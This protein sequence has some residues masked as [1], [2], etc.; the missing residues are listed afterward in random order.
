MTEISKP[1]EES[2]IY[3]RVVVCVSHFMH[4]RREKSDIPCVKV[5]GTNTWQPGP[6]LIKERLSRHGE[7]HYKDKTVSR[8]SYLYNRNP[9]TGKTTSLYRAS[10][11]TCKIHVMSI[12]HLTYRTILKILTLSAHL[13]A[14]NLVIVLTDALP[15]LHSKCLTYVFF[16]YRSCKSRILFFS[17]WQNIHMVCV[18]SHD[19]KLYKQIDHIHI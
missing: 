6:V 16:R 15:M 7:F 4:Q 18:W 9:H 11:Q 13:P 19:S 8:P 2:T 5:C 1:Y 14:P 3:K 12:H 17:N 10:P